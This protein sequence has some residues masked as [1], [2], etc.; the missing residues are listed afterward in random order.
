MIPALLCDLC[1]LCVLC[2]N[3]FLFLEVL[4]CDAA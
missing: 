2:V 3:S 1:A 4:K